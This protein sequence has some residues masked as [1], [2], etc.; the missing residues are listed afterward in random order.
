MSNPFMYARTDYI[1]DCLEY[2]VDR[3]HEVA[4]CKDALVV[5]RH[6]VLLYGG[7]GVGKTFLLRVLEHEI[8]ESEPEVFPCFVNIGSLQAYGDNDGD[9]IS[10]FPRAVLLQLCSTLWTKLLGKSYLDL[11]ERLN[12]TGNE[13]H[14]RQLDEQ[15]IQRVYSHLMLQDRTARMSHRNSVGFSVG[16]KGEKQEQVLLEGKHSQ[17]LPFEFAEFA[18]E[19]IENVLAQ[20]GKKAVVVLCDEANNIPLFSQEKILDR[21]LDLF[22]SKKVQ[23][24]FVAGLLPWESK[25]YLPTC[26]ETRHELKGFS[27]RLHIEK[28]ISSALARSPGETITFSPE[29]VDAV[30]RWFAGNPR[31]TIAAC[32]RAYTNAEANK[33][34]VVS[35]S[36]V[37]WVCRDIDETIKL[38]EQAHK[39][40]LLRN[41]ANSLFQGTRRD[42]AASRP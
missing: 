41:S 10:S 21:Y 42:N 22:S 29:A 7:R 19:L 11:R 34:S 2:R 4:I 3:E 23:F 30:F 20:H 17:I 1:S 28:L 26:F 40:D 16:A 13:L 33:V 15:T 35:E 6:N 38:E 24:L 32:F 8:A 14:L 5:Q 25:E 12:E 31:L 18:N 27:E 39:E 9:D 37:L 36:M